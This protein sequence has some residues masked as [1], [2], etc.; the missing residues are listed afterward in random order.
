MEPGNPTYEMQ[1]N[2][3][4][5]T[6]AEWTISTSVH[7]GL[8]HWATFNWA[9]TAHVAWGGDRLSVASNRNVSLDVKPSLIRSVVLNVTNIISFGIRG[10]G[11]I[12]G[13][14]IIDYH[15]LASEKVSCF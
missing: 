12:G 15:S 1:S 4:N 3:L 8:K 7:Q 5:L 10:E 11:M 13:Q 14:M 6:I 2:V 9:R